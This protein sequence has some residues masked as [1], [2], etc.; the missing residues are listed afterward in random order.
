MDK[1]K[2]IEEMV[3]SVCDCYLP[4]LGVCCLDNK[5]CDRRCSFGSSAL[6]F[7]NAGYRKIDNG[8]VV[9]TEE[10]YGKLKAQVEDLTIYNKAYK[11]RKQEL[12]KANEGLAKNIGELEI[13]A[14]ELRDKLTQARKQAVKEVIQAINK[15]YELFD[16]VGEIFF[17]SL[18]KDIKKIAK[19]FGVEV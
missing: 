1:Q 18:R 11:F 5:P 9:L 16:D 12:Q 6:L 2:Q 4:A 13:E 15:E 17:G 7:Y 19:E 10:E 3:Q 8:S 14:D